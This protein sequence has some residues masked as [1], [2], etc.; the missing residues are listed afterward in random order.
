MT[1]KTLQ[2]TNE[3]YE[4]TYKKIDAQDK[5]I[6]EQVLEIAE[7]KEKTN[8]VIEYIKENANYDISIKQCRDNLFDCE[9]DDLLK[10]LGDKKDE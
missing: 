2:K 5:I 9:C 4:M 10:L 1:C 3:Q 6:N 8:K 7:L